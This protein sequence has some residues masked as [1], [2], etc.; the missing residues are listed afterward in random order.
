MA[1][2]FGSGVGDEAHPAAASAA[3]SDMLRPGRVWYVVTLLVFVA[4]MAWLVLGLVLLNGRIDSFQRVTLPGSGEVSLDHSGGY[5]IYYEGPGA[6]QGNVP[7]FNVTVTPIAPPA[8]VQ[9]LNA[10][11]GDVTYS[12]GSREGRAVLTLEI[13]QPGRFQIEVT[14]APVVEGGSALVVGGSIAGGILRIVLPSVIA[15]L[16][17][18]GGA[19]V[20]AIVRHSRTYVL[21][22]S[23]W[24]DQTSKQAA[25]PAPTPGP[26]DRRSRWLLIAL[27]AGAA[28]VA[29]VV[30]GTLAL[31]DD[32]Q[33]RSASTITATTT[34]TPSAP[35]PVEQPVAEPTQPAVLALG[36]SVTI[37]AAETGAGVITVRS[38]RIT[39]RPYSQLLGFK[40]KNGY[41]LIF[42]VSLEPF[43]RFDVLED[44]FHVQT[45]EGERL[46]EGNGNSWDAVNIDN[47]LDFAEP[48]ASGDKSGK[49]VFDSP[50]KHGVL[51]FAPNLEGDP[52]ASWK[53]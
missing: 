8:A 2:P 26:R 29:L 40:P 18:I 42:T 52:I 15:M 17:A 4:G 21:E 51:V 49:L 20:V 47:L 38:L 53:F 7:A 50:V 48:K 24:G 11:S 6:A 5:V 39:T 31:T 37:T 28:V 16:A 3:Q 23:A 35:E 12:F 10:Y 22:R 43:D 33:G 45:G 34:R 19:I 13:S 25:P 1:D 44:D 41:F 14:D 27:I 46:K 9:S 30:S 36:D 32:D